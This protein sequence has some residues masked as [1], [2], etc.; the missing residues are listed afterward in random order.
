[1]PIDHA[2]ALPASCPTLA[3]SRVDAM[4]A[5]LEL[6]RV[7]WVMAFGACIGSLINVLVYR[8]PRGL[9]YIRPQS[10]CP[11]CSTRLTWRE[12][13]PIFGWL[14]LAGR[15]RFCR[16]KISPEYPIVEAFVAALWGAT[17]LVCYAD[18]GVWSAWAGAAL[19]AVQPDWARA[20]FIASWPI[21]GVTLLLFSCLVA[22]TLVD[23]KTF[24][25]PAPLTNWPVFGAVIA[26][27][28]FAVFLS[29]K[30]REGLPFAVHDW[31]M[32]IPGLSGWHAIGAA[33]GGILGLLIANILLWRG[34]IGRS[35]A[36]YN[37]WA[38]AELARRDAAEAI[39][40]NQ[41]SDA[42]TAPE[43]TQVEPAADAPAPVPLTPPDPPQP[44]PPSDAS[45]ATPS[46]PSVD[47]L[48]ADDPHPELFR[49]YPHARREVL[50]ELLF[51]GPVI[52]LA[53]VGAAIADNLAGP[54]AWNPA[55]LQSVAFAQAPLWLRVVAGL[56]L[57]YLIGGGVVWAVR[58]LGTLAFNKE[59]M[60]LGDVHMM[61]A[62]GACLGWIDPM[63]AFFGAAI[64]GSAIGI[65]RII[66]E[67][68]SGRKLNLVMPFGPYL[69]MGTILVWFGKPACEWF[70]SRILQADVNLP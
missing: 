11:S 33:I 21:F 63:L 31:G 47:A 10:R 16:S 41:S 30:G 22:M 62:V 37:D 57:G 32:W 1:M 64:L 40:A 55:T 68:A 70:L 14:L 35:F 65:P 38:A 29:I 27:G 6:I 48:S 26:H 23:A 24:T 15:C 50:R 42:S 46:P 61:A 53:L 19:A 8:M 52:A 5:S 9:D 54:W 39:E 4:M 69:A 17:Y 12:N 56:M 43:A 51:L 66:Y 59:A 44:S 20:G 3:L 7:L 13:I 25:I 28:A 60:G 45:T 58:I 36:D 2:Q 18:Q 49:L 67:L 34:V